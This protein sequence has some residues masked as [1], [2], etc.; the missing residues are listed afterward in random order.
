MYQIFKHSLL[1]LALFSWSTVG[2][3][4]NNG[5]RLVVSATLNGN[6]LYNN[7]LKK[8][9]GEVVPTQRG[10]RN[11]QRKA[12]AFSFSMLSINSL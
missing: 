3:S 8:F 12:S 6:G 5:D 9:T 11:T 2:L 1:V 4:N 10:M 7:Q